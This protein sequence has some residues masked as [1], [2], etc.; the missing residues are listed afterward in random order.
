MSYTLYINPSLELEL[1]DYAGQ[2][3][4]GPLHFVGYTLAH[5]SH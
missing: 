3:E 1:R 4:P 2:M 5:S